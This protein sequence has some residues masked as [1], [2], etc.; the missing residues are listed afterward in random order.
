MKLLHPLH[1]KL[2]R[3]QGNQNA[4]MKGEEKN[5]RHTFRSNQGKTWFV[6]SQ[7]Y[8]TS[9]RLPSLIQAGY[10]L[11][12]IFTKNVL[13]RSQSGTKGCPRT[14]LSRDMR[15]VKENPVL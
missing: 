8:H 12:F 7:L 15:D 3:D 2:E 1:R 10:F 6:S 14:G 5:G 9:V 13:S 11:N 4:L